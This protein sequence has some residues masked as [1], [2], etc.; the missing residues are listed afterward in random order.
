MQPLKQRLI[1]ALEG[2]C[3]ETIPYI[4]YTDFYRPDEPAWEELFARG[5]G[6]LHYISLYDL[7]CDE[8]ERHNSE[9]HVNGRILRTE[10]TRTPA[11]DLKRVWLDGWEQ[12][13]ALK[14]PADYRIMEY[15]V[16][17]TRIVPHPERF[18]AAEAWLG[19]HGLPIHY[20]GR[21]PYQTI[22]VDYAGLQNFSYHLAD[23]FPEFDALLDAQLDQLVELCQVAAALPGPYIS[24]LENLTAEQVGPRRFAR[25]HLPVYD[26]IFP[27]LHAAGKK[28]YTHMDGKLHSLSELV[29]HSGIDGIDSLTPPPEGDM[30]FA[31]ARVTWPETFFLANINVGV[32]ELPPDQLRAAVRQMARDCAPDG[33]RTA[34]E[35]S[36]DLPANWKTALPIVLDTLASL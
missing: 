20:L 28:V 14:T 2:G 12:E 23:A 11:G 1:T 29:A 5:F 4:S 30:T 31:R 17:H 26:R 34:F 33:R 10:I 6:L 15:I 19:G 16:R 36:E 7:T 13:Y 25:Y 9:Q 32:Y 3:P 24:L 22:L 21:S 8:I 35:V 18:T 27:I